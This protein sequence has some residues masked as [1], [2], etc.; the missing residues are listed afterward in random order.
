MFSVL[1][2]ID[3]QFWSP[4]IKRYSFVSFSQKYNPNDM[5]NIRNEMWQNDI[6]TQI[7]RNVSYW[8]M[9]ILIDEKE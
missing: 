6:Q 2:Q 7:T 3:Q 8:S 4:N 5:K 1:Q 9:P